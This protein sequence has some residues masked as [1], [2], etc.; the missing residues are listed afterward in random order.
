VHVNKF[1]LREGVTGAG[2]GRLGRV[3]W[4]IRWTTLTE[5]GAPRSHIIGH[6]LVDLFVKIHFHVAFCSSVF[7]AKKREISFKQAAS[8]SVAVCG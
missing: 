6:L 4:A 5:A 1:R 8:Y 7:S 3:D 2:A